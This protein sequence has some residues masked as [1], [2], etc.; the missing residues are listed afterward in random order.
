[1]ERLKVYICLCGNKRLLTRKPQGDG[2]YKCANTNRKTNDY[3]TEHG[4]THSPLYFVWVGIRQRCNNPKSKSY[5]YYG[6]K[7]VTIC[8]EWDK[9]IVFYKWAK[10]NGWRKGMHV[11][12]KG[13]K[14]NYTPLNCTIKT[15][16][17]NLA[18]RNKK[19]GKLT[20]NQIRKAKKMYKQGV[21]QQKIAVV[22]G[23][24]QTAIGYHVKGITHGD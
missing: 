5:K 15:P 22:M 20:G 21:T 13:D 2:C 19:H 17:K 6:A 9:F 14:G 16:L 1:M 11:S 8:S 18:E 23:V 24:T 10:V 12:R 4:K 3:K 7:G